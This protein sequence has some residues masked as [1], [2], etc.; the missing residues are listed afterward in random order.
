VCVCVCVCVVLVVGAICC[1]TCALRASEHRGGCELQTFNH[2]DSLFSLNS[3][4]SSELIDA[5]FLTGLCVVRL[6]DNQRKTILF[7]ERNI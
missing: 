2:V 6:T 3:L 5:K 7:I 4:V 1:S